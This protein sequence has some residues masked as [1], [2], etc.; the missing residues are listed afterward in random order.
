MIGRS[1][2]HYHILEKLGEGGMGVVYKAQDTNLDRPVALK[3]LP[4]HASANAANK[5]RFLQ[6]AKA[7]AAL[8]HA[9]ICTIYG[10][11]E[12]DGMM[13]I[14]MEYIEGGTLR[15]KIP[16]TKVDDALTIGI[17]IGDAL[18]EAHSKA[19]VHRDVKADNIMLTS[20]GHVK[21]MDFGLAKL[22]GSLKVTRTSSTVGTLGYMAPEQIQGGEIDARSDLFSFGVLLFEMLTGR[23]PFRGEHEAALVYSIVHEE[24][25][26]LRSFRDD[27]S[28]AVEELI[29]Q[30]LTK[31]K[32]KRIQS[33]ELIAQTLL[34][35]LNPVARSTRDVRGP[36][37][38]SIRQLTFAEGVEEYPCWL[39]DGSSLV[40]SAESGGYRKLFQI[41]AGGGEATQ[42]THGATDDIQPTISPDGTTLLFVR[43]NRP[44][45]KLEPGDVFGQ[46]EGGDIW[47]LDLASRSEEKLIQNAFN[48]SYSRDGNWIAFDASWAGPRRIW[49]V[50]S[51]GRNPKQ[52]SSDTSEAVAH[53]D[54]SWAHDGKSIAFQN[55]ERTKFDLKTVNIQTGELTSLTN[56]LF[57]N[58]YPSWSPAGKDIFFS[59]FRGGGV[60]IWH[61]PA[62]AQGK[63]TGSPRQVTTGAGKDVQV[64]VSPDGRRIAYS[65]LRLNADLWTL[66]VSPATGFPT[67][68]PAALIATTREE[69]RGAWSPDGS[70]IAFNS[71][72]NGDM[73]IWLYSVR[74]NKTRQLTSG[75][76]GDYQP[77][78]SPDGKRL[79]FFSSR[80]G[81]ADIWVV[82]VESGH[83]KQITD[84]PALEINPFFSP[85]GK[86]I[87]FHSDA[88]GRLE[89]WI[90]RSDGTERRRLADLETSGHFMRWAPD[91]TRLIVRSPNAARPGLWAIPLSDDKPE[92]L[93]TPKGG[94][95]ISFSPDASLLMDVVDHKEIWITPVDGRE[96]YRIFQFDDPEVRIDYPVWSPD[97]T[98]VLFDRVRPQGGNIWVMESS[99]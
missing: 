94:A 59:S 10:V 55:I 40:Y 71:D 61:A 84:S 36:R 73:N 97:G 91:G 4:A 42:L 56:D 98:K 70:R 11:E 47:S 80:S 77:S 52:I 75:P 20:K 90:M 43:S 30:C 26:S 1:V 8:N 31:D 50:D 24:P 99:D 44:G 5:A 93:F 13:F 62:P 72:R 85:D 53:I 38:T 12:S 45:G 17:Q 21:V 34:T 25:L 39:P 33:A 41:Q 82:E 78:W 58:V 18:R 87:A 63:F 68:H 86:H 28:P 96:P 22:K 88:R 3:F 54:P 76:G 23:L 60:N 51:R 32:A 89:P 29:S 35:V 79:T 14:A 16:F 46:H 67:G 7:A 2:S 74:E 19:I 9:N 81:A 83:L 65:V 15:E 66:P 6:E 92:F 48:P 57:Q 64:A 69:S 37:F 27:L 95:H 49:I